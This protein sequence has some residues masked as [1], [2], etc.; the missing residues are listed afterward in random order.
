MTAGASDG[1][2]G[3][4]RRRQSTA[5]AVAG[6]A[7]CVGETGPQ[8]QTV[9]RVDNNGGLRQVDDAGDVGG[10]R[11]MRC[12]RPEV[13]AMDSNGGISDDGRWQQCS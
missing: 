12:R 1:G 8:R 6:P 2:G 4:Q 13:A 5:E 7:D 3:V 10:S 11:E 9:V